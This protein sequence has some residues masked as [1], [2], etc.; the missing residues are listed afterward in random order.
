DRIRHESRRKWTQYAEDAR[1]ASQAKMAHRRGLLRN[2]DRR[3]LESKEP[4]GKIL[5]ICARGSRH[6][7]G[8]LPPAGRMLRR[9]GRRL[10]ELVTLGPVEECGAR[11]TG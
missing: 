11:S 3:L 2:R 6:Q 1:C 10:R 8:S 7:H 4:G 9:K 5:S